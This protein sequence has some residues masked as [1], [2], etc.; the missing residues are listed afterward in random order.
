MPRQFDLL[1]FDWDG[2]LADS[3][4]AIVDAVNHASVDMALAPPTEEATRSIIGLELR[5]ALR[6]LFA[7]VGEQVIEQLAAR[8]HYHY[9]R[10]QDNI[11]LFD[12]A[13]EAVQQLAADGFML[14]VAS[15]KGRRGLRHAISSAGMDSIILAERSADDCFSKPHPQMLHEL[16]D[17]LGTVPQR[18]VMI[19]DTVFDLQMAQNAGTASLGVTYG[20]QP[21]ENL[22][23]HAPLATFDSFAKL[24]AWLSEN[25]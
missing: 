10:F 11:P 16:M 24:H 21:R 12:G 3:T 4:R 13:L 17:E 18:T 1:V 20:A 9:S 6:V 2:T 14:A 19:G 15:G 8:Y 23:P 5:Q 22:L 7:N 25:A